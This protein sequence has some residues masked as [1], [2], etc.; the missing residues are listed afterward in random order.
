MAFAFSQA[1]V[2]HDAAT[3]I[4]KGTAKNAAKLMTSKDV[5]G[6]AAT[7]QHA[8]K[9]AEKATGAVQ[10]S[11]AVSATRHGASGIALKADSHPKFFCLGP[12]SFCNKAS[13]MRNIRS[14]T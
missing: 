9:Q 12:L 3:E 1:A 11:R 6:A 5:T 13:L 4:A 8:A 10:R 14:S 7:A 2:L